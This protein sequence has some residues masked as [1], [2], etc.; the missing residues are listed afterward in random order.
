MRQTTPDILAGNTDVLG[1]VLGEE[2][3]TIRRQLKWDYTQVAPMDR[4]AVEDAAVDILTNGRR[5]QES[6]LVIGQRLTE[7]KRLLDHGQFGDWCEQEFG[8]NV[9][10]AQRMMSVATNL[11]GKSDKLSHLGASVLYL[12]GADSTPEPVRT[13]VLAEAQTSPGKVSVKRVKQ[14]IAD[15]RPRPTLPPIAMPAPAQYGKPAIQPGTPE[16]RR[17]TAEIKAGTWQGRQPETVTVE[18]EGDRPLPE[19][20]TAAP[21]DMRVSKA[22]RLIDIYRQ[23]ISVADEYGELT[24]C[25]SETLAPAREL[26]KMIGRLQRLIDVLEGRTVEP[27]DCD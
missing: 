13:Q 4:K 10:T 5:M 20:A 11:G 12:I 26:R 18:I 15:A 24:G 27:M 3:M 6:V 25:H 8:M 17:L 9:R 1:E 7:A 14:M 21:T 2:R 16:A 23:A 19:W 22:S